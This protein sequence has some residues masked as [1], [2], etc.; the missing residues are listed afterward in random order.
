MKTK[1]EHADPILNVSDMAVSVKYYVDVLGFRNADWGSETFTSVNRDTAGIYLCQGGQGRPGTWVWIGVEDVAMLYEEYTAS[2]ATIL[3][4]P[5][6][7]PW[8]YEMHVE[9]PDGHV[10][11][12]GSEPRT[13]RPY[14]NPNF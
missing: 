11:R 4:P 2:G 1:F 6:N 12:F 10:L 9:D 3:R 8:A 7:Y 5:K 13:D 14:D